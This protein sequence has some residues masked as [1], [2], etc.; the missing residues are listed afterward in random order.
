MFSGMIVT[1]LDGKYDVKIMASNL[2]PED[3]PP[4]A[5]DHDSIGKMILE[6][7]ALQSKKSMQKVR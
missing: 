1:T 6:K 4:P 2:L 3:I 5:F 7:Y